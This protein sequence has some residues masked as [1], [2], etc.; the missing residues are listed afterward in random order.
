VEG[1]VF[2]NNN[3]VSVMFSLLRKPR[4]ITIVI[5]GILILPLARNIE[6]NISQFYLVSIASL[7][8]T[9]GGVLE[10]YGYLQ[11]IKRINTKNRRVNYCSVSLIN[12]QLELYGSQLDSLSKKIV[13][14]EGNSSIFG[15]MN[16][17]DVNSLF[18]EKISSLST[19]EV[20]E[21]LERRFCEIERTSR[22]F[23]HLRSYASDAIESLEDE[24]ISLGK[25]SSVQM[26]VGAVIS[27][28]GFVILYY[29]IYLSKDIDLLHIDS[30]SMG[31]IVTR[32]AFV[33]MIELFALFF[34]KMYRYSAFEI[35]YFQNEISNI[36]LKSMAVELAILH[37]NEDIIKGVT[38]D[39]IK[40]E[41]NVV[42]KKGE[43][44]LSQLRDMAE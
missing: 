33:F 36:Y 34:L 38:I 13:D 26:S 4:A 22:S 32:L 1:K 37:N 10:L 12:R 44:T 9:I 27:V 17:A 2:K 43:L 30:A 24:I 14:L 31:Y 5:I 23:D 41:R 29:F 7:L 25:R 15:S 20:M 16:P 28:I 35:K 42:L 3:I 18:K 39:L 21:D 19:D 8:I 6:D 40:S 11:D